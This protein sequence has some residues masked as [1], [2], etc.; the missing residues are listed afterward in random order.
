MNTPRVSVC[1][2]NFNYARFLGACLESI[3]AQAQIDFE[4]VVIDD[5]S[6]D[7]SV[8]IIENLSDGRLRYFRHARRLGA[9]ATWNHCLEMA[10]GEF[11]SFICA[12]DLFLPGKLHHQLQVFERD[13]SIGIVHTGGYW[14]TESG[15]L[16]S[17]FA[18]VFPPDVQ[19]Y[20]AEDHITPAPLELRRL[21]AGYNYIHLSN[22]MFRRRCIARTG[23]FSARFP[24]AADWD[25]WLRIAERYAVGYLTER[26]AAYRR[27]GNNLTLHMQR[28]GQEFRDWYG[29]TQAVFKRWPIQAG[30]AESV[31]QQA[32]RVI[33]EHLLRRIHHNYREGRNRE[34][35]RDL[36]LGF[37]RDPL[38]RADRLAAVTL[39]KSLFGGR[40]TRRRLQ[41]W[42]G[43]HPPGTEA[44][45]D[46]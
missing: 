29:V 24:Y 13:P 30:E 41:G 2:P 45:H 36:L 19:E 46:E 18:E 22:A 10:R 28:T 37:C 32:H 34:V 6:T 1:L 16:E 5:A 39:V 23:G 27:H 9:V 38:I 8:E 31:K 33:R 44:A 14:M 4:L 7:A 42:S 25:L 43:R 11:I 20:L 40:S 26:L 15:E 3:R 35:C 12:D 17:A 21:A